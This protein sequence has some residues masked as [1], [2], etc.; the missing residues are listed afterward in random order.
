LGWVLKKR[1]DSKSAAAA[2]KAGAKE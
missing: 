1:K 2:K